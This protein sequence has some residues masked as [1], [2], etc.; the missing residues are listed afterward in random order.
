M[1]VIQPLEEPIIILMNVYFGRLVFPRVKYHTERVQKC[2]ANAIIG[3]T[4]ATI[5]LAM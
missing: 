3:N 4:I 1:L 5:L 2:A